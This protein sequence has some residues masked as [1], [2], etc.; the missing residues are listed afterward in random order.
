MWAVYISRHIFWFTKTIG[1][2]YSRWIC[3]QYLQQPVGE[4]QSAVH[5]SSYRY[6]SVWSSDVTYCI[7]MHRLLRFLL[8]LI[9]FTFYIVLL[10]IILHYSCMFNPIDWIILKK[11]ITQSLMLPFNFSKNSYR[12]LYN[13]VS[14]KKIPLAVYMQSN[15]IHKVF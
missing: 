7:G 13:F 4:Y 12:I 10:Y 11:L 2:I 1:V 6:Q 3:A 15:K 8:I 14:L 9:L 5:E